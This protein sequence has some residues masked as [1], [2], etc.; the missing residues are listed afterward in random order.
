M[1]KY[2]IINNEKTYEL[3]H[4]GVLGQKW[5][6]RRYQ[7][8][9]GKLTALGKERYGSNTAKRGREAY[10]NAKKAAR[11]KRQYEKAEKIHDT[12]AHIADKSYNKE[13]YIKQ[14]SLAI[15]ANRISKSLDQEY[16]ESMRVA[17]K[18]GDNKIQSKIMKYGIDSPKL[19]AKMA[20]NP[21]Y[22]WALG[23]LGAAIDYNKN[24]KYAT[25]IYDTRNR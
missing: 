22:D 14:K 3:Y 4:Y 15:N 7:D 24:T 13:K 25:S 11:A 6:I 10:K 17:Q 16:K 23:G 21:F 9:S 18:Y 20:K 2:T 19:E 12:A 1:Y 8:A 5:G